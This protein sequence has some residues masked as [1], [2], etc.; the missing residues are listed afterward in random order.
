[1]QKAYDTN[2]VVMHE[3]RF[4]SIVLSYWITTLL[5]YNVRCVRHHGCVLTRV[6]RRTIS[7][8]DHS[9]RKGVVINSAKDLSIDFKKEEILNRIG[10]LCVCYAFTLHLWINFVSLIIF[11]RWID[12]MYYR[13]YLHSSEGNWD[14]LNEI[15]IR[16][17]AL[18]TDVV[19]R[20]LMIT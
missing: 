18:G 2:A 19:N 3:W 9:T 4:L 6:R 15:M 20:I 12:K 7:F 14:L 1:M 5:S 13:R 16:C 8:A 10:F 11:Q 17:S